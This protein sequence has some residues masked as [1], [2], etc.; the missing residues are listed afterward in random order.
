MYCNLANISRLFFKF[1]LNFAFRK[2]RQSAS[3]DMTQGKEKG[4]LAPAF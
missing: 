2:C 1:L 4:S 3:G